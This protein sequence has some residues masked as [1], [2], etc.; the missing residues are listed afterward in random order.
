M[1]ASPTYRAYFQ[2]GFRT[3]VRDFCA[4]HKDHAQRKAQGIARSNGWLVLDVTAT[5]WLPGQ[6][7]NYTKKRSASKPETLNS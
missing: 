2:A 5:S 4:N 3:V 1:T 7:P 6:G